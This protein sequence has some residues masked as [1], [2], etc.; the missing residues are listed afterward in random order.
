MMPN[1]SKVV[2]R[3]IVKTQSR[4]CLRQMTG[5]RQPFRVH[6]DEPASPSLHT[7]L[8]I[9]R[10]I[11]GRDEKH[12]HFPLKAYPGFG[13]NRSRAFDLLAGG[14]ERWTVLQGPPA[15]LSVRQ[16]EPVG[17]NTL[18]QSDELR[19]LTDVVTMEHN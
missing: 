9:H 3:N 19:H 5:E 11:V 4:Y 1:I 6:H 17:Q 12:F 8:R 2:L 13:R 14:Q 18:G 16:L 15:I 10:I 7:G